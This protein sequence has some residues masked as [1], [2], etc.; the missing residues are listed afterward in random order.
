MRIGLIGTGNVARALAAGWSAA[1]HEVVLGSRKPE[2]REVGGAAVVGVAEAAAYGE[3]VVNAT[4]GTASLEV[5]EGIGAAALEGKVLID[6]AVGFVEGQ[7]EGEMV[8][9]HPFRSLGEEIQAAFPRTAV[10]KTL[11]TVD[12][13]VMKDPGRLA[14]PSTLFLSGDDAEA[15]RTVAR[16]LAD[17][18]WT[19]DAL[20][21]LGGIATARGQEQYAMLFTGIWGALGTAEFNV[22]V[23]PLAS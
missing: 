21:D 15:K 16:L 10:V 2:E 5:L 19:E 7:D 8:L 13:H 18:G 14:G 17:L 4:P 23:V 9:S 12:S 1:G 6:V 22:R 3:V 20:M 11:C